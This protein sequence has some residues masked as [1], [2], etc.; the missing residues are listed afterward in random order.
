MECSSP[1]LTQSQLQN[2]VHDMY[3]TLRKYRHAYMHACMDTHTN[4]HTCTLATLV[5]D[6]ACACT[7]KVA[8][9]LA[10]SEQISLLF[11]L[12]HVTCYKE[13][14]CARCV[15]STIIKIYPWQM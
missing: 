11:L 5:L 9:Y 3:T 4:T 1:T 8:I 2:C 6:Y 7:T 14:K 15:A 13:S 12:T 10:R